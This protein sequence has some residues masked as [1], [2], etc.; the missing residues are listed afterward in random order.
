MKL[1]E[2]TKQRIAKLVEKDFVIEVLNKRLKKY[3][4]DFKEIKSLKLDPFK[5]HLGVTSAVFV[6]EYKIKYISTEGPV[7]EIDIFVS[8]HSDGSR[9]GAYQKTKTLYDHGFNQ[10][11]YRV[12]KPLFFLP[13]Q[14]A[15]FYVSSP[16]RSFFNFFTQDTS[17][18]LENSWQ[19]TTGWIKQLHSIDIKTI[20]FQWPSF[21]I[22]NM[23][24]APKKFIKDFYA[25]DK[26]LGQ[27][28]ESLVSDLDK[29]DRK[30]RK[31]IGDILIY[32]D[33]HPENIIM[34]SLEA[35]EI[36]MIDFT[37]IALG[38]PMM[39]LGTFIQQFDFMGHNF[40]SR[41][42]IDQH[43]KNFV[44]TYFSKKFSDIDIEYINRI[45]L[46]QSWTAMRSAIFLFYM[47]DVVNP[48]DDLL[49]DSIQYL[50]LAKNNERSINVN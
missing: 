25:S 14:K 47:K 36:E 31:K 29:L 8:S 39:D 1:L 50:E 42:D 6:V 44:E 9:K 17:A 38:D 2:K 4:K 34:Q 23:V 12:T 19:L 20:D 32:G 13:E 27:S 30:Y 3:Y 16:G 46:Y 15:F 41:Q 22:L 26:K 48:I 45:N 35:K 28:I 7:K 40:V 33:F 21:D 37:D 18:D 5:R 11:K 43:K 49:E 10:G 24:P